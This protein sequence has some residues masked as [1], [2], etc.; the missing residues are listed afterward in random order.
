[1]TSEKAPDVSIVYRGSTITLLADELQASTLQPGWFQ[2]LG[3]PKDVVKTSDITFFDYET[4][5]IFIHA[6][7]K[8]AVASDS[9]AQLAATSPI[10]VMM[11]RIVRE[12]KLSKVSALAFSFNYEVVFKEQA[13][14]FLADKYLRDSAI[15]GLG[16]DVRPAG[17]RL[18]SFEE[19][20]LIRMTLDSVAKN[21]FAISVLLNYHHET[22]S[23]AIYSD[24][25][26][27]FGQ[28]TAAAPTWV[29]K[30]INVA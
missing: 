7:G 12:L 25:I 17:I 4:A 29:G 16:R 18:V 6:A 22:P 23:Q 13:S 20:H 15:R 10:P 26:N 30:I 3:Q 21:P 8:R 24:I 1:V 9:S 5:S 19:D 11:D 27:R 28:Y 2:D 14:K